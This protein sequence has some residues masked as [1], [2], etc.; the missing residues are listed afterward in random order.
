MEYCAATKQSNIKKLY[1]NFKR[2]SYNSPKYYYS[3]YTGEETGINK[4]HVQRGY[5]ADKG[6]G[7]IL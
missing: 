4:Q 6:W 7:G 2:L 3:Y 5:S 1:N